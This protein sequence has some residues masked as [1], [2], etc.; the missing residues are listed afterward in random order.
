M[1][2]ANELRTCGLLIA[3]PLLSATAAAQDAG[4]EKIIA[5]ESAIERQTDSTDGP[6][7]PDVSNAADERR[8][9]ALKALQAQLSALPSSPEGSEDAL[10]R[11][12]LDWRLGMLIEAARFR[13]MA[14]QG[15]PLTLR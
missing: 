2:A 6:G 11:R 14:T 15:P 1:R 13:W 9:A 12:L 5:A 4:L 8:A 3:L 10:T 7:W